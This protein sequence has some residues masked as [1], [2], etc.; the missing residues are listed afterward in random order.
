MPRGKRS[1]AKVVKV[2][3]E[4]PPALCI[5]GMQGKQLANAVHYKLT[6]APEWSKLYYE[7]KV[8]YDKSSSSTEKQDCISAILSEE[9]WEHPFFKRIKT[10]TKID[11]DSSHSEWLSWKKLIEFED[12]SVAKLMISQQRILTRP[13]EL[14]DHD[15][16]AT[17][18]LAE[19]LRL[20]YKYVKDA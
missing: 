10:L 14:L 2:E 15:D 5:K 11:E 4:A 19:H 16:E 1:V 13:H 6:R 12:E 20:Q 7:G 17:Q 18:Q 8:K 3:K 9:G